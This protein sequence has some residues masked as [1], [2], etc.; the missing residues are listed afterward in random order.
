MKK[1]LIITNIISLLFIFWCNKKALTTNTINTWES[2]EKSNT[3]ITWDMK[4]Q[5][6]IDKD[7]STWAT[8]WDIKD[9]I[10]EYKINNTW[11]SDKLNENDIELMEKLID[12]IEKK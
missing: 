1:V 5:T 7:K 3:S 12:K 4:T 8:T 9:I 10:E 6:W 2:L 11:N